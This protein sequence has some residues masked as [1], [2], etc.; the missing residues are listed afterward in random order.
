MLNVAYVG[1]LYHAKGS[2]NLLYLMET[3]SPVNWFVIGWIAEYNDILKKA[4]LYGSYKS[5]NELFDMLDIYAIDLVIMPNECYESFSYIMSEVW[6]YGLPI[7]GTDRGAV[8]SR[9]EETGCG[10]VCSPKKMNEALIWLN[11]HPEEIDKKLMITQSYNVP[12]ISDMY[13][14]YDKLYKEM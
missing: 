9:I 7:L 8:K 2:Y 3:N 4:T 14:K 1:A 11:N 12:T 10:W 13:I 5:K 6:E